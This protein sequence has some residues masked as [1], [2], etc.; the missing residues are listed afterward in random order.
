MQ[1][2]PEA[3]LYMA[4]ENREMD[5]SQQR[6]DQIH[7]QFEMENFTDNNYQKK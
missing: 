2:F 3:A 5:L 1:P 7:P 4:I 6:K